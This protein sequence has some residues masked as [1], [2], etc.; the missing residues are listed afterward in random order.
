MVKEPHVHKFDI[1]QTKKVP[2]HNYVTERGKIVKDLITGADIL[3]QR[4]CIC[5]AVETYSLK[6]KL[7]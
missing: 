5:G 1:P 6:R 2:L 4:A 7:R 3:K